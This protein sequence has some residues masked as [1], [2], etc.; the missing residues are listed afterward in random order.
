MSVVKNT[1]TAEKGYLFIAT[2]TDAG[3]LIDF[4][5][6]SGT[7]YQNQEITFTSTINNQDGKIG[8]VKAFVWNSLTSLTPIS[9]SMCIN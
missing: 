7:Y 8:K 2:Y 4:N 9:N 5:I 1:S 6:M 3:Q